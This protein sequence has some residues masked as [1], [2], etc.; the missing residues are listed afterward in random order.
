MILYDFQTLD[1]SEL[2]GS[3][4]SSGL[5]SHPTHIPKQCLS[6]LCI[7]ECHQVQNAQVPGNYR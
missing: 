7:L 3:G 6:F 1:V 2:K 5:I 4:I